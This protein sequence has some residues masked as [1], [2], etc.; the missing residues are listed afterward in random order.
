[1]QP[2]SVKILIN[3]IDENSKY[4]I[5]LLIY[6]KDLSN[7]F[8]GPFYERKWFAEKHFFQNALTQITHDL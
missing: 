5:V 8:L 1:M 3:T 2:C 6:D 7:H 4:D